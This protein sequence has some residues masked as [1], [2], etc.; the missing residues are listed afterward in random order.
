MLHSGHEQMEGEGEEGLL[1]GEGAL[2]T[3]EEVEG[4][5]RLEAEEVR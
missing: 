2:C 3:P 1:A 5:R 4:L